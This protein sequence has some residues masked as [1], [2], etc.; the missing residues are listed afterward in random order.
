[1]MMMMMIQILQNMIKCN[2]INEAHPLHFAAPILWGPACSF[3][4]GCTRLAIVGDGSTQFL[5]SQHLETAGSAVD[6][7]RA[8]TTQHGT[9]RLDGGSHLVESCYVPWLKSLF[10]TRFGWWSKIG[11]CT[12]PEVAGWAMDD[13]NCLPGFRFKWHPPGKT[14]KENIG[15]NFGWTCMR[16]CATCMSCHQGT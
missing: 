6:F 16:A 4:V 2:D 1:M 13:W 15:I 5:H 10:G 9:L 12:N 7:E 11:V 8:F 3:E 14:C